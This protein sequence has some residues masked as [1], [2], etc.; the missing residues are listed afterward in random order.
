LFSYTTTDVHTQIEPNLIFQGKKDYLVGIKAILR[1]NF[2]AYIKA[3]LHHCRILI[4]ITASL[5][6]TH[7]H[8]F[9]TNKGSEIQGNLILSGVIKKSKCKEDYHSAGEEGNKFFPLC[10]SPLSDS[11][12]T[13]YKARQT[14][15]DKHQRVCTAQDMIYACQSQVKKVL[16]GDGNSQVGKAD[17]LIDNN[18]W[19]GNNAGGSRKAGQSEWIYVNQSDCQINKNYQF[20]GVSD[21]GIGRSYRCCY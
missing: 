13:I 10:I 18:M 15:R 19:L 20:G 16:D 3:R 2:A 9:D 7:L 14:C 6:I 17:T 1:R 11:K 21:E 8:G 12:V 5:W 4:L